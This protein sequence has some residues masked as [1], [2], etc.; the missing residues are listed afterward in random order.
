MRDAGNCDILTKNM[1]S[2]KEQKYGTI[3]GEVLIGSLGIL[4]ES[5]A[6]QKCRGTGSVRVGGDIV[7]DSRGRAQE[8]LNCQEYKTKVHFPHHGTLLGLTV[9][10]V[11][12]IQV[13]C[14]LITE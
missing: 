5:E 10:R 12:W 7:G 11:Q 6:G 9:A 13:C 8:K 2:S 3:G 1:I 4:G 14:Q